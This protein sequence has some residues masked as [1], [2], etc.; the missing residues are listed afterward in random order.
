MRD[1]W[2]SPKENSVADA[3]QRAEIWTGREQTYVIRASFPTVYLRKEIM[4][5]GQKM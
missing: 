5:P 3:E 2:F 4:A 1:N